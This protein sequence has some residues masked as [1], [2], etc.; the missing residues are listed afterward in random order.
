MAEIHVRETPL[1]SDGRR[2]V[3]LIYHIPISSPKPGIAPTPVS[4]IDTELALTEK[5]AL[6]NGQLIEISQ[7]IVKDE[8]QTI[9]SV[10]AKIQQ[11]WANQKEAFNKDYDK[12]YAYFGSTLNATA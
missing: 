2:E 11:D 3:H 10:K 6:A 5:T 9:A 12:K 1:T 8:S 4:F 7:T